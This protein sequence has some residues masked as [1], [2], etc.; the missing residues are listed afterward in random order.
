[1]R[2]LRARGEP[3]SIR[4]GRTVERTHAVL[5]QQGGGNEDGARVA[6]A[7]Q[8]RSDTASSIRSSPRHDVGERPVPE[9]LGSAI[10][11]LWPGV[12]RLGSWRRSTRVPGIPTLLS[13]RRS[14]QLGAGRYLLAGRNAA[15]MAIPRGVD[16]TRSRCSTSR[17]DCHMLVRPPDGERA[18]E[19]WSQAEQC[20]IQHGLH[21]A[22][23]MF[24]TDL[25]ARGDRTGGQ[26]AET[27]PGF[28]RRALSRQRVMPTQR[29]T[30]YSN[31]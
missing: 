14:P 11:G 31:A 6:I 23:V 13:S 7:P 1:M 19:T 3:R 25:S 24:A 9:T 12:K 26:P 5:H 8:A 4:S 30:E 20:R 21:S 10:V 27:A 28:F 29:A 17:C 22:N 15:S 2:S 18:P 16:D